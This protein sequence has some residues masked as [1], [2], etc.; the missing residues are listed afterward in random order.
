ME[1][2]EREEILQLF[3]ENLELG[4]FENCQA[5]ITDISVVDVLEAG[6]MAQELK[7]AQDASE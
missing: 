1:Q 4:K 6:V 2:K 3:Q 5:L 7:A